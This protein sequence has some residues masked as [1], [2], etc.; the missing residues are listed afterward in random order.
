MIAYLEHMK[1]TPFNPNDPL[2]L[3][4]FVF[5]HLWGITLFFYLGYDMTNIFLIIGVSAFIVYF[6]YV[7]YG[8][9]L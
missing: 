2:V 4:V 1:P 7:L 8:K 6:Y 3:F 9:N 5:L